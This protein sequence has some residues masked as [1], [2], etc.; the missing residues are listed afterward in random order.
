MEENTA[1][2][3]LPE[4]NSL[5]K[6]DSGWRILKKLCRNKSVIVGAVLIFIIIFIAIF[7]PVLAPNDPYETNAVLAK[8]GPDKAYPFGCDE[9]GRCVLSR[10]IYGARVTIPYSVLALLIA[11]VIGLFFGLISGYYSFLDNSIMRLMDVLMAFPGML[12]AIAIIATLGQGLINVTIAVGL[13]TMPAYARLIRGAVLSLKKMPY[14]EASISAGASDFRIIIRHILP[15][16]VPTIIVYSMLEMAWIIMSIST[17]SFLGIGVTPPIPE[18]GALISSGKNFIMSAPHISG[19]P[20]I[21]ILVTVTG[22]NLLGDGLRDVL[23]P[24]L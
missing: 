18:W 17:L 6:R 19:F 4:Q 24:R 11:V 10:M 22:F 15:N 1:Y 8:K 23:D 5:I 14:V 2:S 13:G 7:A 9:V 21:F 3:N 12:L 16:C 20:V